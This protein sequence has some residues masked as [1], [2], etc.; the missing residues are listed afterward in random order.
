MVI[1]VSIVNT[2]SAIIPDLMF[3]NT[4][5]DRCRPTLSSAAGMNMSIFLLQAAARNDLDERT[6][7]QTVGIARGKRHIACKC[8]GNTHH[9]Q[10]SKR[11]RPFTVFMTVCKLSIC[12]TKTS[13]RSL[14]GLTRKK[15]MLPLHR[16]VGT[17]SVHLQ[18]VML[19]FQS[20]LTR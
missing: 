6:A 16:H 11:M 10:N 9:R 15:Y 1:C 8:S 20:N 3:P 17:A 18:P 14:A 5:A 7:Q 4:A 12:R 19:G 13:E 2:L